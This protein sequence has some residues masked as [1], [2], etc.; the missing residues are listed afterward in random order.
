M[1]KKQAISALVNAKEQVSSTCAGS[2]VRV[3]EGEFITEEF[4]SRSRPRGCACAVARGLPVLWAV[5]LRQ[6]QR[7]T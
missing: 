1:N 6:A 3:P 7:W 4:S 5:L 2:Q